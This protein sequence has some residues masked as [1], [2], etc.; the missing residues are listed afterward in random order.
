MKLST[1]ASEGDKVA[2]TCYQLVTGFL[3]S[4][5]SVKSYITAIIFFYDSC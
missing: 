5:I 3:N 2:K 4:P 1:N